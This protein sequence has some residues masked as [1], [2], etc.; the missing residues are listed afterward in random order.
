MV[1]VAWTSGGSHR[2]FL[3][4]R[5]ISLQETALVLLT[6]LRTIRAGWQLLPPR[7]QDSHAPGQ[8]Q[9]LP[10]VSGNHHTIL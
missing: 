5:T 8:S 2:R 4:L 10:A 1:G 9:T 3:V 6:L 7:G